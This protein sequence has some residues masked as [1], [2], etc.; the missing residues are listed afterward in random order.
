MAATQIAT[1]SL[2]DQT[3]VT[4]VCCTWTTFRHPS[5]IWGYND[6]ATAVYRSALSP[7]T[8]QWVCTKGWGHYRGYN[9]SQL[10]LWGKWYQTGCQ[11]G[12]DFATWN[13]TEV[14]WGYTVDNPRMQFQSQHIH[15]VA[16]GYWGA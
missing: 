11:R 12:S 9:G 8:E 16:I 14:P 5:V 1:L 3:F 15:S 10:G 7:G 13:R 4:G 2:S 6:A